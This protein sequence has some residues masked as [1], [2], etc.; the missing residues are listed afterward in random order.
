MLDPGMKTLLT[1][2][3][4]RHQEGEAIKRL[5][6]YRHI[7]QTTALI[8]MFMVRCYPTICE[9][10]PMKV[11]TRP[12]DQE[13]HLF[14]QAE[15]TELTLRRNLDGDGQELRIGAFHPNSTSG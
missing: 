6:I 11:H 15:S 14:S 5:V 8:R 13:D 2:G 3:K 4:G 1:R 12:V 9:G 10:G 7:F